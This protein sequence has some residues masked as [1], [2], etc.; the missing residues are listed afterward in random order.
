MCRD[1]PMHQECKKTK[2]KIKQH[3]DILR[4]DLVQRGKS[5]C[6]LSTSPQKCVTDTEAADREGPSYLGVTEL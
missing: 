4:L 1:E 2:L 5:E 6:M 3:L